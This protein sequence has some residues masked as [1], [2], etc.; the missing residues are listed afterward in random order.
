M[1]AESRMPRG[2]GLRPLMHRS[3]RLYLLVVTGALFFMTYESIHGPLRPFAFVARPLDAASRGITAVQTTVA[4]AVRTTF[5]QEREI[6]SLRRNVADLRHAA[7]RYR[8]LMIE[9]RRL[10]QILDLA[11]TEPGFSVAARVVSKGTDRWTNLLVIGKGA[12]HGIRKNMAVITTSG[13]AGKVVE[14]RENFAAVLLVDNPRFA[15]AVRLQEDRSEAVLAGAGPGRA[16]LRYLSV[17][18]SPVPGEP[19]VTSGLDGLFPPG[20]A[21]GTVANVNTP[22]DAL[23]HE[24]TVTLAV[25]TAELEELVVVAR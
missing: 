21:A 1:A 11:S 25:D 5:L 12:R 8:E 20:I 7:G 9:N 19:L 23:F 13:L 10:R 6:R 16:V 22:E 17:D 18:A 3:L 4:D 14:V 2:P 15:A 24:V